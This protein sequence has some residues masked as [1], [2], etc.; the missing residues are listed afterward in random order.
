MLSFSQCSVANGEHLSLQTNFLPNNQFF[1]LILLLFSSRALL[2][3]K[4]QRTAVSRD[5]HPSI[6]PSKQLPSSLAISTVAA[7]FP[8]CCRLHSTPLLNICKFTPTLASSR[9]WHQ[10]GINSNRLPQNYKTLL[11][12][13]ARS[14]M[15]VRTEVMML[16]KR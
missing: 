1:W 14:Y 3:P 2:F 13:S 9:P 11:S 5:I 15:L 12:L 10:H 4:N 6:H 8:L 16:S 7:L